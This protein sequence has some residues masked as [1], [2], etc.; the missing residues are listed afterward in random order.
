M[1]LKPLL[2]DAIAQ[3]DNDKI[4]GLLDLI[5][6]IGI[7]NDE[8]VARNCTLARIQFIIN[9]NIHV[10]FDEFMIQAIH[11]ANIDVAAF[12]LEH[13]QIDPN[14]QFLVTGVGFDKHTYMETWI[15]YVIVA[16][17]EKRV[18]SMFE[19]KHILVL[20]QLFGRY[21]ADLHALNS[22]GKN[23]MSCVTGDIYEFNND[24]G[25]HRCEIDNYVMGPV[26]WYLVEHGY[27][28]GAKTLHGFTLLHV[29]IYSFNYF[30]NVHHGD[31]FGLIKFLVER[32]A[33]INALDDGGYTPLHILV[34]NLNYYAD[35]DWPDYYIDNVLNR[36]HL[37]MLKYLLEH[38]A[39]PMIRCGNG[40]VNK[41]RTCLDICKVDDV[42]A[43]LDGYGEVPV[44]GVVEG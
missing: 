28:P 2:L 20:V 34:E 16:Y 21:G 1:D 39:D 40:R 37:D 35:E 32:G 19:P 12:L 36:E 41:R 17:I 33:D 30:D 22:I 13:H 6:S 38:G 8:F 25:Y 23:L 29:I 3:K 9:N 4:V 31:D 26:V 42:R 43:I 11:T 44:K 10:N 15:N 5:P 18:L 14:E 27:S 7:G 24:H